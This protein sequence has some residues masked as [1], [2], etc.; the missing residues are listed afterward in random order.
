[1][2][3]KQ[4]IRKTPERAQRDC[5]GSGPGQLA[6]LAGRLPDRGVDR[7]ARWEVDPSY[8]QYQVCECLLV[9]MGWQHLQV[10]SNMYL[11]AWQASAACG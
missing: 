4:I 2:R 9:S 8:Y 7:W 11:A 1:M 5:D 10:L 6:E 3:C